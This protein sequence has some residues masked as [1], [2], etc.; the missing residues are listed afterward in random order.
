MTD[1]ISRSLEV[2]LVRMYILYIYFTEFLRHTLSS[3]YYDFFIHLMRHDLHRK[4]DLIIIH[5]GF[6]IAT[7][8]RCQG[9]CVTP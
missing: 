4:W 6:V 2:T 8:R 7:F 9:V 5:S 3:P 1:R